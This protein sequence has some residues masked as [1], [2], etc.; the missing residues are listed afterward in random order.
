MRL[1]DALIELDRVLPDWR[2]SQMFDESRLN[3]VDRILITR[4]VNIKPPLD[5]LDS[6]RV[7]R[8]RIA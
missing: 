7:S 1:W 8:I 6:V 2:Y 3:S 4:E 5:K